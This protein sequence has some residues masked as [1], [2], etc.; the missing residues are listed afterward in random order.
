MDVLTEFAST[1]H[2]KGEEECSVRLLEDL[3]VQRQ[4]YATKLDVEVRR[5]RSSLR[6][7]LKRMPARLDKLVRANGDD[8]VGSALAPKA[9]GAAVTL[10]VQLALPQRLD[11]RNLHPYRL[12]VK[13]LRNI[14]QMADGADPQFVDDLRKVKDAIGE[15]HDWEELA[16]IAQERLD[17]GNRCGLQVELGRIAGKKYDEALALAEALR[18]KYLRGSH[19]QKKGASASPSVPREPVWEA[20]AMLAA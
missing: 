7:E 3:G 10:A 4:K 14:L 1:V 15:W 12:K 11:K 13:E 8:P 18:K 9:A 2:L 5:F 17:H 16:S 19:S 20:I 6:K